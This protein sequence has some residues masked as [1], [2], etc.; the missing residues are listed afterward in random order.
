MKKRFCEDQRTEFEE[1][2]QAKYKDYESLFE[3]ILED[4]IDDKVE[5]VNFL[6]DHVDNRIHYTE[7]RITRTVTLSVSLI[8][9]GMAFFAVVIKL[10][11]LSLYLGLFTAGSMI[12][13]GLITALI[14]VFQV[15]PKYPFRA[16]KN[17]WKWFYPRIVD[18]KYKPKA[19]VKESD[20]AYFEKRMLHVDGLSKYAQKIIEET[21]TER[22]KID[23]QQLF[24]LHVNEKYKNYFLTTLRKCLN[25]GLTIVLVALIIFLVNISV[26]R[27]AGQKEK[28][29]K[30][31][32]Q[33][34]STESGKPLEVRITE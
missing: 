34:V 12:L 1:E 13:T 10:Q 19:F 32:K 21:P 4:S 6:I 24:L 31:E 17:D 28:G 16:L 26:E 14:H 22:L 20:R 30:P 29:G 3:D 5:E 8:A 2:I 9:I 27:I 33:V 15:N 18:D 23:I 11:S 25:S 7:T